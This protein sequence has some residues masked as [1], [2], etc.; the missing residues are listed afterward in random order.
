[1][2]LPDHLREQSLAGQ[3]SAITERD[4]QHERRSVLT[5]QPLPPRLLTEPPESLVA[6]RE[7]AVVDGLPEEA[8]GAPAIENWQ[9]AR[10]GRIP[11]VNRPFDESSIW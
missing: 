8:H 2:V 1:V 11:M 3:H 5:A 10:R 9:E 4:G 6:V 7:T